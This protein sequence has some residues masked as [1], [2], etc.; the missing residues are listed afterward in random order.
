VKVVEQAQA[1]GG[2]TVAPERG[3]FSCDACSP[4]QLPSLAFGALPLDNVSFQIDKTDQNY[5]S[6]ILICCSFIRPPCTWNSDRA[7]AI[8]FMSSAVSTNLVD[9]M[10]S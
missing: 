5:F 3:V 2:F 8:S 6:T 7:L 10:F 1:P 9:A 4:S